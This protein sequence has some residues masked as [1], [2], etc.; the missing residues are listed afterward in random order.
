MTMASNGSP[1]VGPSVPGML[2]VVFVAIAALFA[3]D[4]FLARVEKSESQ[5]EAKQ[6]LEQG[7]RLVQQ[8]RNIEAIDRFRSALSVSRGNPEAQLALAGA[9]LRVGRLTDAETLLK[10]NLQR[11]ATDGAANL[12]MARVLAAQGR[13]AEAASYYHQAIYGRWKQDAAAH[14]VRVRFELID[15][16]VQQG[17]NREVLAELLPLQDEAPDD[18]QTRKRIARLYLA[19]GSP[20]RA[21]GLFREILRQQPQDFEAYAG[22][23]E[24]EFAGGNYRTARSNFLVALRLRPGDAEAQ[25]RMEA[26]EAVLA[27]DPTRRGLSTAE[28]FRRS[29]KLVELTIE[30]VNRCVGTP[31]PEDMHDLDERARQALKRR[32]S[33][34]RLDE[35]TETNLELTEQLWQARTKAC[36][37]SPSESEEPLALVIARLAQ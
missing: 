13:A 10:E 7:Q 33:S 20:S 3:I 30:S 25:K 27:L 8:G 22:L 12:T 36:R 16:L 32:V 19:A 2:L 14:R 21:R 17:A 5:D 18:L 23:G 28:R 29:M 15:L 35:A 34:A 24:A 31:P 1:P 9:L 11:N 26:C 4:T 6:L 37:E